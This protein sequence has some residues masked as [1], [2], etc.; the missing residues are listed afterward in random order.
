[1]TRE[2]RKPKTKPGAFKKRKRKPCLFCIEQTILDY[3]DA[4][5]V[6]RFMTDRG[7]IAPR[8]LSG[9]CAEHQRMIAKAIKRARQI[10]TVPYVVD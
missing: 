7:K 6:K 10:G 8:R 9:C 1:M 3:K 4:A 5:F 2:A